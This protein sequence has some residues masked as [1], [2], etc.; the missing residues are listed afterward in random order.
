MDMPGLGG[1]NVNSLPLKRDVGLA[2]VTTGMAGLSKN[3]KGACK[4]S[5]RCPRKYACFLACLTH[6]WGV[7]S[8]PP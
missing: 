4:I 6:H 3:S 5:P 8:M 2:Q 7:S 1:A